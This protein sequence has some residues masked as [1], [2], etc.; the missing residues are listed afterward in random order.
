MKY[1]KGM[2]VRCLN[3][4]RGQFTPW[5]EY[6]VRADSNDWVSVV[7]DDAGDENGWYGSNFEIISEASARDE[8]EAMRKC[9]EA[10]EALSEDQ[11]GRVINYL[12]DRFV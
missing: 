12:E 5:R 1:R 8:F 10:L 2:K 9:S 3:T 4:V 6:V 11:R 7:A